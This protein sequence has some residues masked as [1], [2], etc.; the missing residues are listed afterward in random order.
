MGPTYFARNVIISKMT[1]LSK[2]KNKTNCCC[3][4]TGPGVVVASRLLA[5]K[6]ALCPAVMKW[7]T[8]GSGFLFL[9]SRDEDVAI[10][11]GGPPTK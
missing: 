11:L 1:E 10:L 7:P 3:Q 6:Q 2:Y 4:H 8:V 5:G 9:A